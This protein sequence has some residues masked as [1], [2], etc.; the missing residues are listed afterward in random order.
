MYSM[1]FS[2]AFIT[3]ICFTILLSIDVEGQRR[4]SGDTPTTQYDETLYKGMEW[5]LVGPFRGGRAGTVTGVRGKPNLYYMGTAGGGVWRSQDSGNSWECIS[6]GY[7][8][9]FNWCGCCCTK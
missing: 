8:R 1:K 7:L 4:R 6:D 2:S 5:R 3:A 9:W